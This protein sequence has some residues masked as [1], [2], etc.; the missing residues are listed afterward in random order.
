MPKIKVKLIE[1][2]KIE[3]ETRGHR[4]IADEP[5]KLGGTD[6]GPNPYE[7]LLGALGACTAI[8]LSL[9]AQRK[10]L[11]LEGVEIIYEH[12]KVHAEDCAECE[13]DDTGLLDVVRST[14]TISGKFDAATRQRL[15]E[16]VS[17]CPVHKTLERAIRVFDKVRFLEEPA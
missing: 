13:S 11:P 4:W 2:T 10:N 8:T 3:L 9:Y 1:G 6:Q 12:Q 17:R 7:L 15:A 16:I 5:E 14:A